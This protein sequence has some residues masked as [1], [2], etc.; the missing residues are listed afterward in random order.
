MQAFPNQKSIVRLPTRVFDA[1][2]MRR[3]A[4]HSR[5]LAKAEAQR[6]TSLRRL[7]DRMI[8]ARDPFGTQGFAGL[9]QGAKMRETRA[10]MW[11]FI[12]FA[13]LC[14]WIGAIIAFA[15]LGQPEIPP[16]PTL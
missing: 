2:T 8:G 14:F 15:W 6:M 12:T 16:L 10:C 9:H 4:R 11:T 7:R 3:A 5:K 13:G 1:I